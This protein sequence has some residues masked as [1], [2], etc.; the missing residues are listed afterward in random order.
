VKGARSP[1]SYGWGSP[2]ALS[3]GTLGKA[4]VKGTVHE[5]YCHCGLL[6][7]LFSW[8]TLWKKIFLF[9]TIVSRN[10][11]LE[12]NFIWWIMKLGLV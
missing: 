9:H 1:L 7:I 12:F 3:S 8:P 6:T 5:T 2:S 4:A 10:K 11:L